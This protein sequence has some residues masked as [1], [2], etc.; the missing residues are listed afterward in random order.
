MLVA[1]IA[2]VPSTIAA[3]GVLFVQWQIRTPSGTPIGRQLEAAHHTAIANNQRLVSINEKIDAPTSPLGND[4][5][6]HV[7]KLVENG[8]GNGGEH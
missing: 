3:V 4:E 2:G 6:Q 8:Q 7:P 5:E 1:L